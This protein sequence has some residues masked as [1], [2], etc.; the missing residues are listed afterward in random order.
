MIRFNLF[1]LLF[2]CPM[3]MF[4]Q[5]D[6]TYI[7]KV[8]DVAKDFSVQ[9]ITGET[10]KLSDLKGKVVLLNFWAT[11]CAPCIKEFYA[12]PSAV[13]EP[14]KNSDFVLLPVSRGETEQ[15]VKNKMAELK[16]NGVSFNV[17]IDP[18]RSI[19]DMYAIQGIPKNFLIDKNGIIR[20]VSTGY[21]EESLNNIVSM[22]KKLLDEP[23]K[24]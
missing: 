6:D 17:G 14:F 5:F 21:D 23:V 3:I 13:I 10:I 15:L 20:Y 22:I 1:V 24:I 4:G 11:W 7:L 12:F 9:M 18:D 8:N 19:F 2:A 16:K